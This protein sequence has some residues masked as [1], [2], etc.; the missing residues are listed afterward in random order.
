MMVRTKKNSI[1]ILLI[2][3]ILTS[4][5]TRKDVTVSNNNQ[6]TDF[7]GKYIKDD[8]PYKT[9][10]SKEVHIL[11]NGEVIYK[12]DM[13]IYGNH[14]LKGVWTVKED[15]LKLS[16]NFPPKKTVGFVGIEYGEEKKK[17]SIDLT[18]VNEKG[19]D[20]GGN[21]IYINDKDYFISSKTL[22]IN[23][24]FINKVKIDF[25]GE[26]YEKEVNKYVDT[27]VKI[28]LT[29]NEW[30]NAIYDFVKTDWLIQDNRL[31]LLKKGDL[32]EKYFLIKR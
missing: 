32:D 31:I 3:F 28:I 29:P 12:L 1:L 10:N 26:T 21:T 30:R 9:P 4:C 18:I 11:S 19:E 15:T 5:A 24:S 27:D 6:K 17:D 22:K 23:P 2:C 14:E 16:F 25:Y 20:I 8:S 7:T 13:E